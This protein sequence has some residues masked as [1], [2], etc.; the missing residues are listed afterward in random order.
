MGS[1]RILDVNKRRGRESNSICHACPTSILLRNSNHL[2]INIT[3]KYLI[4][5]FENFFSRFL[6]CFSV[7]SFI[8][9]RK[10]E[11][12][13]IPLESW[14]NIA[15]YHRGFDRNRAASTHRI[16]KRLNIFPTTEEYHRSC[17]RLFNRC[18][19]CQSPISTLMKCVS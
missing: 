13:K 2:W 11:K 15:C 3:S 1:F 18:L 19:P 5:L 8:I 12:I 9:P 16:I 17:Q 14:C 4:G 10:V 6:K 7:K